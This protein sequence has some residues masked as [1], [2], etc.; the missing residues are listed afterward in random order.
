MKNIYVSLIKTNSPI[1]KF[2]CRIKKDRVTHAAI[3]LDENFETLYGF[4]RK[5]K[6][7]PDKGYFRKESYVEGYYGRYKTLPGFVLKIEV[8]DEQYNKVINILRE[9]VQNDKR[10]HY[11]VIKLL[12]NI[13]DI[14]V[15]DDNGFICSEF[16]AYVLQGAGI[17][18]FDK[19][20]NLV[21]PQTLLDTISANIIYQGDMKKYCYAR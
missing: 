15:Q 21:R 8:T 18:K 12:S 14:K 7:R 20:L 4:G 5:H 9:F 3:A 19:P 10:Y 17:A 16:V 2:V 13:V 11:S 1:G 6:W